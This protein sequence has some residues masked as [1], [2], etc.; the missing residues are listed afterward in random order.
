LETPA[1]SEIEHRATQ[2]ATM[3]ETGESKD[4]NEGR[5]GGNVANID[6]FTYKNDPSQ[7]ELIEAKL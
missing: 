6:D 1:A 2:D 5:D 4:Q 7:N 3:R